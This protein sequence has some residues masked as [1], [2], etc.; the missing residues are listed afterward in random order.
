MF[1]QMEY[2]TTKDLGFDREQTLVIP[3]QA[4]WTSRATKTVAAFRQAVSG[5]P[6]VATVSG[7]TSS[8]GKGWSRYGFKVNGETKNA[9]VYGVDVEYIPLLNI[10]LT[11]GRAFDENVAS[12]SMGVIVNEA[13]VRDLQWKDPLREHLNWQEDT[14]GLGSP[15]IGVMKDYHFMSL[16]HAVEPMFISLKN[17]ALT[18]ILVKLTPG[19]VPQKIEYLKSTWLKLFPDRPFEYTFLD[20]DVAVQYDMHARWS[21]IMGFSTAFAILIACLGLFGLAGINAVNRTKEIGIRKVM[22]AELGNIFILLNKQY[23][24][25]AA[26]AFTLAVPLSW[27]VMNKWLSSFKFAITI[28][29]ELFAVSILCGLLIALLTVSYHA[30]KAALVNPAETLKYE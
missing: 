3:T 20:E 19:E 6:A 1:R 25:L 24:W 16:E 27:Y 7:V 11:E 5:N 12:D 26:I 13:L 8:F 17:G 2:I 4:G 10:Q 21:K 28:G 29:W 14:V 18:T 30:I 22:G 9:F 23:L 15:V